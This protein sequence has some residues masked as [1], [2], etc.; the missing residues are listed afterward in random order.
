MKLALVPGMGADGRLF[1]RLDLSWCQHRTLSWIPHLP[2]D[3][4]GS[5]ADRLAT[6]HQ[7]ADDEL[8]VGVSMGGIIAAQLAAT[9]RRSAILISSATRPAML[10][11]WLRTLGP[12]AAFMPFAAVAMTPS[13]SIPPG[14][15]LLATMFQAQPPAFL[16]WACGAILAW[17]GVERHAGMRSIHGTADRIFPISRQPLPD[18]TIAGGGHLMVFDRAPAVIR[19]LRPLADKSPVVKDGAVPGRSPFP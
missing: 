3:T 15:R 4:I 13:M 2:H 18:A 1:S 5:Y 12:L 14:K 6:H 10:A 7:L 19:A 8:L 11:P 16:R 17:P 9:R